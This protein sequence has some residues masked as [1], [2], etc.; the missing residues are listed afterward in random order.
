MFASA[1]TFP[2]SEIWPLFYQK[3]SWRWKTTVWLWHCLPLQ[4]WWYCLCSGLF[5]DGSNVMQEIFSAATHIM[6]SASF[7][8]FFFLQFQSSWWLQVDHKSTC[9]LRYE[10]DQLTDTLASG[11]FWLLWKSTGYISLNKCTVPDVKN[12]SLKWNLPTFFF[13]FFIQKLKIFEQQ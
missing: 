10:P 6:F 9:K 12:E 8:Y 7:Q 4:A 13:F 11:H 3:A 2:L 5:P 1:T